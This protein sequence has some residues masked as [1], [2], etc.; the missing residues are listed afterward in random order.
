MSPRA[1]RRFFILFSSSG[2]AQAPENPVASRTNRD[3]ARDFHAK[4]GRKLDLDALIAAHHRKA[5]RRAPHGA[6]PPARLPGSPPPSRRQLRRRA[7]GRTAEP[8]R[9]QVIHRQIQ[10]MIVDPGFALLDA[11]RKHA[12]F[13]DEG[14]NERRVRPVVDLVRRTDLLDPPFAHHHNAVGQLEGFLLVV[15]DED[16][17]TSQVLLWISSGCGGAA[18]HHDVEGPERLVEQKHGRLVR[19][20]PREGER[21]AGPRRAGTQSGRS[22]PPRPTRSSSSFA[23][24]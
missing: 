10:G 5:S 20:R 15:R 17:V 21:G 14:I 18:A 9:N 4:I 1:L 7:G 13:A 8:G 24:R 16:V 22:R 2:F 3:G 11:H 23:R 6:S 19:E 12:R